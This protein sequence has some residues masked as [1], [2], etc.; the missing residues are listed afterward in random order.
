M[1]KWGLL[2][3]SEFVNDDKHLMGYWMEVKMILGELSIHKVERD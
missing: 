2:A 3:L 1:K